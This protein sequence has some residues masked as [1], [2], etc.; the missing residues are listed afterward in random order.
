M[1]YSVDALVFNQCQVTGHLCLLFIWIQI[2]PSCC[3][4]AWQYSHFILE[5]FSL[6]PSIHLLIRNTSVFTS[7]RLQQT[8]LFFTSI[9]HCEAPPRWIAALCLPMGKLWE[10]ATSE[11][12]LPHPCQLSLQPAQSVTV[13]LFYHTPRKLFVPTKLTTTMLWKAKVHCTPPHV[14]KLSFLILMYIRC[15]DREFLPVR[16]GK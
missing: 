1:C 14:E 10:M 16:Q 15:K 9:L 5:F 4:N 3:L 13:L 7:F 2:F 6:P 12:I 11:T 8:L